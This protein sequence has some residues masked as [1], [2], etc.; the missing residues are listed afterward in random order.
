[1]NTVDKIGENKFFFKDVIV[2]DDIKP[3]KDSAQSDDVANIV[4]E[5]RNRFIQQTRDAWK[6]GASSE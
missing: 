6:G 4:E 2:D 3:A 5:A 1:M